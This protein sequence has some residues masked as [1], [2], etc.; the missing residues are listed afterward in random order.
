MK[1]AESLPP[2]SILARTR[3]R[4]PLAERIPRPKTAGRENRSARRSE[5]NSRPYAESAGEMVARR[6]G[7]RST[8]DPTCICAL[9]LMMVRDQQL[10]LRE[11]ALGEGQ[12][13]AGLILLE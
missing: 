6:G 13:H 8:A 5:I 12:L 2:S 9:R 4:V 1:R 7:Q 11:Y 3:N 10:T